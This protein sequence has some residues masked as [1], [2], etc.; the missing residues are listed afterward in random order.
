M[1]EDNLGDYEVLAFP[2]LKQRRG[3]MSSEDEDPSG[4]YVTFEYA[5]KCLSRENM[6]T[7]PSSAE[8]YRYYSKLANYDNLA[9]VW[10]EYGVDID[11]LDQDSEVENSS[12]S[13]CKRFVRRVQSFNSASSG[14]NADK[15]SPFQHSFSMRQKKK[16]IGP[17][18]SHS[19]SQ[20]VNQNISGLSRPPSGMDQAN[21][22]TAPSVWLKKQGEHLAEATNKAGSLPRSFMAT[23]DVNKYNEICA[24]K[25]NDNGKCLENR[26]ITIASDKPDKSDF[27]DD[28]EHYMQNAPT[29]HKRRSNKFPVNNDDCEDQQSLSGWTE[30]SDATSVNMEIVH[31]EYK[32]YRNSNS[33]TS[34]RSVLA[35]VSSKL[36][37]GIKNT[38]TGG[39]SK[40]ANVD[41]TRSCSNI[42]LQSCES[43]NNTPTSN[44]RL[45]TYSN[46]SFKDD[47]SSISYKASP[48]PRSSAKL[49]YSIAKVYGTMLK[50]RLKKA[51]EAADTSEKQ[52]VKI[53]PQP[54]EKHKI[55]N[56][57]KV[58]V[59]VY[60][61]SREEIGARIAH[62]SEF[63]YCTLNKVPSTLK[64][65]SLNPNN[66]IKKTNTLRPD[67]VLSESSNL[68]SSSNDSDKP[69]LPVRNRIDSE[70]SVKGVNE[71]GNTSDVSGDS[72]Y[73]RSFEAIENMLEND[74]FRDSAIYSDQEDSDTVIM[75]ENM[76]DCESIEGHNR[77]VSCKP[78]ISSSDKN[79][80]SINKLVDV[81]RVKGNAILE[82]L[83][84]L[85]R[86]TTFQKDSSPNQNIVGMKSIVQRRMD[87][88]IW[89]QAVKYQNELSSNT[90]TDDV[91]KYEDAGESENVGMK[92]WVKH[93][94]GKFQADS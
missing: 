45:S 91:E 36:S 89:K 33:R 38:I 42:S 19:H 56:K 81:K 13:N 90:D 43:G 29:S 54:L 78:K 46:V 53:S 71:D 79:C 9:H 8:Y 14:N 6:C 28:F 49:V 25:R 7:S 63:D 52:K 83:E 80:S 26:P 11:K 15:E 77:E 92:G 47:G 82:T 60:R 94:I 57:P 17:E 32:I 35:N 1:S 67:S 27:L 20:V 39:S 50:H 24:K 87:L 23:H 37:A 72:Y 88:E 86:N 64:L 93:V 44:N 18:V 61:K 75:Q 21:S 4:D 65:D 58:S 2:Q 10:S 3:L 84:N 48:S 70:A 22:P 55:V 51:V 62:A 41:Q 5:Q 34:L 31:P 74:M 68:T 85:Q 59:D 76:K 73:E 40:L 30:C 66:V 69:K 16:L 12:R